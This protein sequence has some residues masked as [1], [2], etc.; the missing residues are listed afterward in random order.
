[1]KGQLLHKES[2]HKLAIN[3]IAQTRK[4]NATVILQYRD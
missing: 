3:I 4:N 1:M 2:Y